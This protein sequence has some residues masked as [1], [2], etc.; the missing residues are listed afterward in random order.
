MPIIRVTRL[1]T[2]S[3][4]G[5]YDYIYPVGGQP[6]K[7]KNVLKIIN[8]ILINYKTSDEIRQCTHIVLS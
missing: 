1:I 4:K 6:H 3:S 7:I 8:W 2:Y 5:S